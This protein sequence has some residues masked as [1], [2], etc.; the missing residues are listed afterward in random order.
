MSALGLR[1]KAKVDCFIFHGNLFRNQTQSN[2]PM[3]VEVRTEQ[4]M[5][6]TLIG[7]SSHP[8]Q[9]H[10]SQVVVV[11]SGIVIFPE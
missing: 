1:P 8:S 4:L 6:P 10:L 3:S 5:V 11:S 9:S 7:S 2:Q